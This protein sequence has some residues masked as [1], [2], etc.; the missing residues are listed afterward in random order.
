MVVVMVL[1]MVVVYMVMVVMSSG[2]ASHGSWSCYAN[3]PAFK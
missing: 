3:R 2:E 1:M